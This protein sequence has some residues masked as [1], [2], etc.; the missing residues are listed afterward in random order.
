MLEM[1]AADGVD[2][3]PMTKP[4]SHAPTAQPASERYELHELL[5][6]GGMASVYRATDRNTGR[7]VA[8][9]QL[10]AATQSAEHTRVFALFEREF[11]TL[12]QLAHPHVIAVY[13]YGTLPDGSPFYTMELLDGGDL[14]ELAPLPWQKTCGLLFEVC[15]S[16]GLLHSRRLLHR[17]ITPRNIRCTSDGRAKLIDFGAMAHMSTGGADVVGT[18]AFVAPETVHR[19]ALD[20]RTDLYSLGVTFYYT[21]TG[22]L[23]YPAASFSDVLAA[24]GGKVLP[25]SAW[26]RDIPAA[27]D[28]LVLALI[29]LEPALRPQSAAEVMQRL[30]ACAGLSAR[31]SD[32]VGAAY[33]TTPTLIGREAELERFRARLVAARLARG[34]SITLESDSGMGRSRLLNA[35]VLEAKTLGFT[36]LRATASGAR[37]KLAVVADLNQHLMEALPPHEGARVAPELFSAADPT[38]QSGGSSLQ[39]RDVTQLSAAPEELRRAVLRLWSSAS[40][41]KPLLIAVDDVHR[42]DPESAAV[43][44]DLLDRST[45]GRLFVLL[46]VDRAELSPTAAA[47]TRRTELQTLEPFAEQQTRSLLESLFGD[48]PNLDMLTRELHELS[49]GNPGRCMELA[50]QL[51]DRGV[52]RYEAG[53]WTLP[54][55]LQAGDL[56]RSVAGA[57][58]AR[59]AQLSPHA[60]YLAQALALAFEPRFRDR[61]LR[62]LSARQG[63]SA[64]RAIQ[65]LLSAGALLSDGSE[66][67]L[68]SRLWH[69]AFMESL[70]ERDTMERQRALAEL[71]RETSQV[72]FIY[73]AFAGELDELGLAALTALNDGLAKRTD[74]GAILQQNVGKMMACYPRAFAAAAR[75]GKSPRFV[76]ELRRWNLAGN[77]SVEDMGCSDSAGLW[78]AQ[79]EHDSGLDLYR[80]DPDTSDPMARLMRALTRAQER[81]QA[82]P[83]AERVYSV[84]EALRLLAEYVVLCIAVGARTQDS[85]LLHSLPG[86][87]EPFAALSPVLDAIWRNALATCESTVFGNMERAREGWADVLAKLDALDGNELPY[88]GAIANAVAFAIGMMDAQLGLPSSITYAERLDRDPYQRTSAIQL[89]R[90]LRLEHGDFAGA[91]RLR[92]QAEIMALQSHVPPMFKSLLAIELAASSKARDLAGTQQAV[93]QIRPIAE[94]HA[95]W[96]PTLLVGEA[97]FHMVRGDLEEAERKCRQCMALA[98]PDASGF[99]GNMLMWT[100]VS[101]LLSEVLLAQG[102]ADEALVAARAGFERRS[103]NCVEQTPE[104]VIALALAEASVGEASAVPRLEAL[105]AHKNQLGSQGLRLGMAYEARARIA[106]WQRDATTFER[107]A[108]LTARE[109]RYG[110]GSPLGARYERLRN[111][112][113]RQGLH[114]AATLSD[115]VMPH[116]FSTVLTADLHS[117]VVREMGG[118][119]RI[120]ERAASALQLLCASRNAKAGQLFLTCAGEL[121]LCA[122][123]GELPESP[124]PSRL[125]EFLLQAAAHESALDDMATGDMD[126]G[127]LV[128]DLSTPD[129]ITLAGSRYELLMLSLREDDGL[130]AVGV[131]VLEPG[132]P[133]MDRARQLQLLSAIAEQLRAAAAQL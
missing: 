6:R 25:P 68:S 132:E 28:D 63:E 7:V 78:R 39:L 72:A 91:E 129:E 88:V 15:S 115:Y 57:L 9:K 46:S 128:G 27:I 122:S 55:R 24:W 80:A 32:D 40:R 29:S 22:K 110:A 21:L 53:N 10:T 99:S 67:F 11:H 26:V 38:A 86:L 42:I 19:L 84:E 1:R 83:E 61:E 96:K 43:L 62:A 18:P 33:L 95:G 36:V 105:I 97:S 82:T 118:L 100:Q 107:Y 71:Y 87:L 23:P 45:R 106:I 125:E 12:A 114:A 66:Y 48:V 116:E 127:E 104:L 69:A 81:Y 59:V 92:R 16:L 74:H 50:Q 102:R 52:A 5:G 3:G 31:E 75:L 70:S 113:M 64:E 130:H 4:A 98:Q 85:A 30:A 56:P 51:V 93:E 112:A 47:L 121:R 41:D 133:L 131:A 77:T 101:A 49:E 94:Q 123:R 14:R 109:Y 117:T 79:L 13:D 54:R 20:A 120:E 44:A 35:C 76:N 90:I 124:E 108:E 111:E 89:R 8:L 2:L 34:G 17:D 60:R 119:E 103:P 126:T 37:S 73:H 65:E 58:A